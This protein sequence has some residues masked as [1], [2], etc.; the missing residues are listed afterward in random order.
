MKRFY[1]KHILAW[2][3]L[4]WWF[5]YNRINSRPKIWEDDCECGESVECTDDN[6]YGRRKWR[7]KLVAFT[8]FYSPASYEYGGTGW[9]THVTC[10]RCGRQHHFSDSS[11]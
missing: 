3:L 5:L 10:W 7:N 4:W 6:W 8:D 11:V 9:T 1:F 2:I